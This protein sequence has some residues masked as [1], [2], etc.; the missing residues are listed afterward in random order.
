MIVRVIVTFRR[1][2]FKGKILERKWLRPISPMR[3]CQGN[4]AGQS[5]LQRMEVLWVQIEA[6]RCVRRKPKLCHTFRGFQTCVTCSTFV[7]FNDQA[8]LVPRNL[9]RLIS[10]LYPRT[11]KTS[12]M[13]RRLHSTLHAVHSSLSAN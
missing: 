12:L 7:N 8:A 3:R 10:P 6:V 2:K 1:S 11:N 13:H 9:K 4:V 5:V